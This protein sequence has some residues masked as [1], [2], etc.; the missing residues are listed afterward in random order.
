MNSELA[1]SGHRRG[2]ARA[3]LAQRV[4]GRLVADWESLPA[5][6]RQSGIVLLGAV[7]AAGVGGATSVNPAA[8]PADVAV[9]FR[10]L[11]IVALIAAGVY[12]QS[13]RIQIR[14]GTLLIGVGLFSSLWLLNGSSNPLLFS[15]GVVCSGLAPPLFAYL[16]LAHP[17]GHLLSR[18][19]QRFLRL[20]GGTMA[21]LWLLGILMTEQ[22]PLKTPL[23]QCS[24]HCP[25]NAFSLGSATDAV[26]VVK[27]AIAVAW[28]ALA[29]GTP[30][31]LARRARSSPAPVRR[32]LTPLTVIAV[33]TPLL[34]VAYFV[35]RAVGLHAAAHA[36]CPLRRVRGRRTARHP[37]G[38]QPRAP[39]HGADAGRVRRRA[40]SHAAC[41]SRGVDGRGA[42]RPRAAGSSTAGR[43]WT[44]TWTRPVSRSLE[45]PRDKA[46]SWLERDRRPVAAVIYDP[47][48]ADY[49]R[50]V[51]AAGAAALIR[52]EK[53]QLEADLKASTANLAASRVRLMEAAAVERRRLE[54]DLHDGVQQH[55]VG[56][57][58]KLELATEAIREDPA[59]GERMLASVGRQMDDLLHEVRSLARGIYP[60]VLSQCG[61]G[62][63]LR[64]AARSSAVPVE[65]RGSRIGRYPEDLEV[66]VYFCCLEAL[67]NVAKH[68]GEEASA[69][70]TLR[71]EGRQLCFEVRDAGV[72]FDPGQDQRGNG[73][74]QHARP[75]RGDRRHADD[76][77]A[78][79]TGHDRS[80]LRAGAVADSAG[81]GACSRGSSASSSS[82]SSSI[83]TCVRSS[84]RD[85]L[86][87]ARSARRS[88]DGSAPASRWAG[89]NQRCQRRGVRSE[90][91][92]LRCSVRARSSRAL[93]R[94]P[95]TFA[96]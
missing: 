78:P 57:R 14:M 31:L 18:V 60:S 15:V 1:A 73:L 17:T 48:I 8:A 89:T 95:T 74:R 27:A 70:L 49:E 36:R 4:V 12:A 92:R 90:I 34:L 63:A 46:V 93:P 94:V 59:H 65:V 76:H 29:F 16:V 54:R 58:L 38:A 32:S 51:H 21:L 61:L 19:E 69:R 56:L 88:T 72:G 62:E 84:Y 87:T 9:L 80:R 3:G 82:T 83:I 37:R 45:L 10:V 26:G 6:W 68:A 81:I 91:H 7:A 50:F 2:G 25:A 52:L 35:A 79:G 44:R 77:H 22:P 41:G 39:V 64:A 66:A 33:A 23:L 96:A 67:Q 43:G 75:D 85:S 47:D 13:S 40:R 28:L 30:V 24:P 11:V 55:L 20:T 71:Q 53:A 5:S 42:A 86:C